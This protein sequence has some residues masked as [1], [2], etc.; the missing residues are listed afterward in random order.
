MDVVAKGYSGGESYELFVGASGGVGFF[1]SG[2]SNTALTCSAT[3]TAGTWYHLAVTRAGGTVI[4]YFNG[5]QCASTTSFTSTTTYD[6]TV[7]E[8]G[9]TDA[10][11]T[12]ANY[13]KGAI[14]DTRFYNRALSASEITNLYNYTA[15]QCGG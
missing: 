7:A 8:I 14:D 10:T 15:A 13:F 2:G 11:G 5:A 1:S 4:V 12:Q 9:G 3:I 6:T